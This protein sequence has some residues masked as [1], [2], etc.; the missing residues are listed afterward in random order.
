MINYK[1]I[2]TNKVIQNEYQKIDEINPYPF[3]HG[4]RHV[5]NVCNIMDKL[6][7][8]LNITGAK[9]EALLIACALHDVGQYDGRENHGLKAR[10]IAEKLFDQELKQNEYYQEIY[11][12]IEEHDSKC[13]IK[14]SLFTILVQ[15]ADKMDFTKDRL[16][17]D[18]RNHYDYRMWEDTNSIDFIYNDQYFGINILTNK[19]DNIIVKFFNENFTIKIMNAVKVLAKKLELNPVIKINGKNINLDKYII[20][21]G[22][23]GSSKSN[24][25]PWLKQELEKKELKVNTPDMPIGIGNQTYDN[26]SKELDK[27]YVDEDT[28]LIGH[29][30]APIFICKYLI[31][32]KIKVKKLI[33]IQGFNHGIVNEEYDTVNKTFFINGDVTKIKDYCHDIVCIYSDND[34][35]VK[36]KEEIDNFANQ[37]ANT[38][39]LIKGAGHINAESGY[40]E[41]DQI[42]EFI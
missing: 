4:L 28:T 6:C 11:A 8:V 39:L 16:E 30:I 23:F 37:L 2:L 19:V 31:E 24:W 38:K 20:I 41:F 25:F 5:Y 40:T 35:Y 18:Y 12:A 10:H 27:L 22:S 9:K 7:N 1:D 42:L 34:P 36:N 21:H 32:N 14:Y 15:F 29:S 33:F 26:W 13:D 3:N 17:K